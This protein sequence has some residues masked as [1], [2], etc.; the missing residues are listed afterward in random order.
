MAM[1]LVWLWPVSA[2]MSPAMAWFVALNVIVAAI[3]VT[4][5]GQ[6]AG[7][8]A[9]ASGRRLCRSASSM[10]LDRLRSFSMFSAHHAMA[11]WYHASPE[12]EEEQQH[13]T[14]TTAAA[15][16]PPEPAVPEP[17]ATASAPAPAAAA[18]AGAESDNDEA[19]PEDTPASLDDEGTMLLG[20]QHSARRSSP[21]PAAA[22]ISITRRRAVARGREAAAE[23]LEEKTQLNARAE[24]FIRQ[25]REEL[26]L[27]RLNSII[28]YTRG[29]RRGAGE[30]P[31][32]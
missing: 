22:E 8:A 29:L 7:R 18:D 20:K 9:S 5:R 26:K 15:A 17:A 14:T 19:E 16:A 10:V 4:S 6:L 1:Q 13:M 3:A 32:Q 11:E 30:A 2:W 31:P 25:F 12:A 21:S 28:N 23:V 24:V 27:Q